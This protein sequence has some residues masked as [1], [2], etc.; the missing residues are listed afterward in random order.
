MIW[1]SFFAGATAMLFIFLVL[2]WL[3][4]ERERKSNETWRQDQK[5]DMLILHEFWKKSNEIAYRRNDLLSQIVANTPLHVDS[6]ICAVCGKKHGTSPLGSCPNF[7][8]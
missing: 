5:R 8:T 6:E 7:C 4:P 2:M 1:G 3:L